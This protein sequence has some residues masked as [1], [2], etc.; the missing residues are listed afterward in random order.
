[1]A[2]VY[3]RIEDDVQTFLSSGAEV[4]FDRL[5]ISLPQGEVTTKLSLKL[6]ETDAT[7]EFSWASVILALTASADVRVPVALMEMAQAA[8]PQSGALVAMGILKKD[9]DFYVVNA[10]YRKGL[11]TVNG[12]PM[13]IPLPVQ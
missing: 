2:A 8:N 9:G 5:D 13:P 11:L 3:P 4:R 12:A 10:E 1:L 7:G 6:P